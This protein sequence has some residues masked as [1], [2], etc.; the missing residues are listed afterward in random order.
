[1]PALNPVFK[2]GGERWY[3]ISV[4]FDKNARGPIAKMR[5]GCATGEPTEFDTKRE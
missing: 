2:S 4:R 3:A 5:L 1:M